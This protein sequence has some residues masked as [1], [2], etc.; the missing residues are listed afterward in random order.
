MNAT[1]IIEAAE[2]LSNAETCRAA[3]PS[4]MD[5]GVF[6]GID[7]CRD[8]WADWAVCGIGWTE[9]EGRVSAFLNRHKWQAQ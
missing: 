8:T 1:T 7:G 6:K 2:S 9:D 5:R 3:A 4:E